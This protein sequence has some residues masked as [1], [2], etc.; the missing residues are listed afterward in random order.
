MDYASA[1]GGTM[2]GEKLRDSL[3]LSKESKKTGSRR[4]SID[5][6]KAPPIIRRG[7]SAVQFSSSTIKRDSSRILTQ[8]MGDDSDDEASGGDANTSVRS[9]GIAC[10]GGSALKKESK[11]SGGGG[12]RGSSKTTSFNV[13][14]DD[15]NN[16][17]KNDAADTKPT[18]GK[19]DLRPSFGFIDYDDTT[20]IDNDTDKE[21][22]PPQQRRKS[23]SDN[24]RRGSAPP[25]FRGLAGPQDDSSTSDDGPGSAP[26][27]VNS[28][29]ELSQRPAIS[30]R[31]SCK[32]FM[33]DIDDDDD[34]D[35]GQSARSSRSALT[36]KMNAVRSLTHGHR[37]E[38]RRVS[39]SMD[40][41][42]F[43][44]PKNRNKG[45]LSAFGHL[46]AGRVVDCVLW[47]YQAGYGK[48]ML[49]F[50]TFYVFNIFFW[51]GVMY[52]VDNS[53]GGR[54]IH[55]ESFD[56][57]AFTS[58][59]RYEFAFELSWTT[60]TTVGYGA[61]GPAADVPRCYP[62]RLV[63]AFVAFTGVLFGS[64]TA[65]IMY[66]KLMR[67][68][69]KAHVT[70]SS[71]LCVQFGR[72]NEGSTVRFGQF[73]FR[74]SVAPAVAMK[75]ISME[76]LLNDSDED[77]NKREDPLSTSDEGF[78]VIE[79]RMVNDRA[80][81]EGSEIWDAQIRGIIQLKKDVNPS[82]KPNAKATG[83]E[84][85]LDLDK[86]AYY[87][88]ALTPDS[89]PHFS[90]IWYARHVLNAESPLL[91]RE[92]RDMIVQEGGKWD[93]DFNTASEIRQC[94]N[95]FISLRITLSGTSAV[96]ANTVFAE[97]VYEYE[98][99]VVGW[100]FANMVYEQEPK[101]KLLRRLFPFGRGEAA[102]VKGNCETFTKVDKALIHDIVPQ[103]GDDYEDLAETSTLAQLGGLF[104]RN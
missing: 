34:G 23:R 56:A 69:A 4:K 86:K 42:I 80:N 73:N 58:L 100:R 60:F 64:T 83:G 91:K 70:F 3:T 72:G 95:E 90:R 19:F 87:Q 93:K 45:I 32:S 44:P 20:T 55:D 37:Q 53:T 84:S 28:L 16:D 94:L 98:D 81:H 17:E 38:L 31:S 61:I 8:V 68:L 88:F 103:P 25:Q 102:E 51:A 82:N 65:A 96:S 63:C 33:M 24:N 15:T 2:G 14:G 29:N 85:T 49:L 40:K 27:R 18:R 104:K 47:T 52:A 30:R 54:C 41:Q 5:N 67:L 7:R 99:V 76:D 89:H 26:R 101:R 9:I 1:A 6:D 92:I 75:S 78:P 71:T 74:A 77:T 43:I 57:S 13:S 10:S 11:Y 50:L 62:I 46:L 39:M 97:H 66:S 59:E 35:I 21:Q 12:G 79:F 36:N 22:A 48:V